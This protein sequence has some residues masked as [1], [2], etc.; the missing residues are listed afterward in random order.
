MRMFDKLTAVG[1]QKAVYERNGYAKK[2][3]L[4]R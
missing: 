3:I 4:K 2:E 1:Y